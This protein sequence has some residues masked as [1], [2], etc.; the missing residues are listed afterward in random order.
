MAR[1]FVAVWPPDDVVSELTALPRKDL[2]GVRFVRPE[3]WH[4]TLRF[5]GETHPDA[6]LAA[7]EGVTFDPT[8]ARLGPGVDV[9]A[10]RA[11]V[12]PVDGV[13]ELARVVTDR[14]R[15]LGEPAR[16]RFV[17]H[18]T[19]A[20]VKRHA[21]MPPVLGMMVSAAFDVGEVAL[22]QSR[23]DPHGARYETLATWPVG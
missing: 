23:L 20:R 16:K 7:L 10:D 5:L 9:I 15:L 12:V 8:H 22:V 17:G 14:T 19:L 11:V 4:V 6:V 3:S 2:R 13:G 21:R 18:L 1:L